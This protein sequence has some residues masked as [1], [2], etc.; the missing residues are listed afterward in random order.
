MSQFISEVQEFVIKKVR[1]PHKNWWFKLSGEVKQNLK[2]AV[3]ARHIIR[4]IIQERK[5]SNQKFDDLL[6]M[7]LSARYEDTGKPMHE[8]QY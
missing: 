3:G 4:N 1:Q 8:E 2:K 7:L 5:K 6:D